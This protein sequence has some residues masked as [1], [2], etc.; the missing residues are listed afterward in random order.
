MANIGLSDLRRRL[1]DAIT[2]AGTSA[3][4]RLVQ[5]GLRISRERGMHAEEMYFKAQQ[6]ILE[7]NFND[8]I[9]YLDSAIKL[10]PLDGAAYNDR[11]LCMVEMG[12]TDAA[13][14]YF[15]KG[16]EKEPDYATIYHNK[17]W[18]LNKI[19]EHRQAAA[20]F[21]KALEIEPNRAV[22]YE[23]LADAY[24][25]LGLKKEALEALRKALE[26]LPSSCPEIREQIES[27]IKELTDR[28]R[29]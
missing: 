7:G 29:S 16:I 5:E 27:G 8:A 23:N 25:N 20:L 2:Y 19:G 17:G 14:P 11:A 12:M 6:E 15:D 3:A 18:L 22:T 4:G 10:N 13:I 28:C 1:D 21:G 24:L 9:V 26:F